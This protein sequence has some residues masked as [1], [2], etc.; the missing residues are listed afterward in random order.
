MWPQSERFCP[1]QW[2]RMQS[3]T[4][5]VHF[6]CAQKAGYVLKV[7]VTSVIKSK[8]MCSMTGAHQKSWV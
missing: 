6:P 4:H 7:N 3:H 5:S 2:G 8:V 1:T